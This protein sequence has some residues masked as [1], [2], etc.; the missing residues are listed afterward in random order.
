MNKFR[1]LLGIVLVFGLTLMLRAQEPPRASFDR[2]VIRIGEPVRLELTFEY[3]TDQGTAHIQW[4]S[5]GDTLTTRKIEI[6][7]TAAVERRVKNEAVDPHLFVMTQVLTVTSFDSGY[8]AVPPV[9]I[10]FNGD[11]F[12]TNPL[13]LEVHTVEVDTTQA[14]RDIKENFSDALTWLDYL[15]QWWKW[16]TQNW[17][18][19]LL[20]VAALTTLLILAI[21]YFRNR[22]KPV[23][24]APPV[25]PHTE[26]L[27]SLEALAKQQY[28]QQGQVKTYYIELSHIVRHYVERRFQVPA[29]EQTTRE[30]LHHLRFSALSD[31][32]REH[33]VVLLNLSDLVKFA[34]EH[35][36]GFENETVFQRALE[37][38]EMTRMQSPAEKE[39]DQG[40]KK[41]DRP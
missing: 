9:K 22:R 36:E 11:T 15:R 33:L 40:E 10:E 28:W 37:F 30:V 8:H 2:Q 34:K 16:I 13:L 26:A 35:P 17:L 6:I 1:L 38:I 7:D 27:Q 23:Y 4:P 12:E 20:I 25:P 21:R 5:F 19:V 14:F 39:A 32:A 24:V 3:R 31:Q 18:L 41:E 29:M